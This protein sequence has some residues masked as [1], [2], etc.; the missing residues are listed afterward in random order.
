MNILRLVTPGFPA[1]TLACFLS[2][3]NR[4][5]RRDRQG[6]GPTLGRIAERVINLGHRRSR[7]ATFPMSFPARK[8]SEATPLPEFVGYLSE[9]RRRLGKGSLGDEC[10][11]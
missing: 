10:G 3:A 6:P 7:H 2:A 5:R 4:R 1:A 9:N 11:R 8:S